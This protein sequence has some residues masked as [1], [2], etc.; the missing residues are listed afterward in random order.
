LTH[1]AA[2][3]EEECCDLC[4]KWEGTGGDAGERCFG[5]VLYGMGCFYKIKDLPRVHQES[6]QVPVNA[7][8]PA[9]GLVAFPF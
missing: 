5:A 7:R 8:T 6:P 1:D 4:A 9:R 3:S 2:P